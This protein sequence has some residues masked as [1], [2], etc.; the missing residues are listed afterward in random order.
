MSEVRLNV[1]DAQAV[2]NGRIHGSVADAVIASLSAEPETIAELEAALSRFSK[3]NQSPFAS[4]RSGEDARPWDAGIVI[5][6]MAGR[7]IAAESTYS[8]PTAVGEIRYHNGKKGTDVWLPYRIPDDWLIVDSVLEYESRRD[9]RRDERLARPRIDIREVLYG[10]PLIDFIVNE[11]VEEEEKLGY[12]PKPDGQERTESEGDE[13]LIQEIH[14][15][16]L[17]TTLPDLEDRS[18]RDVILEKLNFIDFDLQSRELQWSTFDEGP[19]P[20]PRDSC[21]YLG[22]GFGRHEYL[23]YYDFVRHLLRRCFSRVS[24]HR[25]R[26]V[27]DENPEQ[28]TKVDGSS[29]EGTN[30]SADPSLGDNRVDTV[31]EW[32]EEIGKAWLNSPCKELNGRIPLDVIESERRRI[33]LL[34]SAKDVL[35]DDCPYCQVLAEDAGEQ[36]GKGFW[37]FDGSHIDS[38]F[39]FSTYQTREEWEA[40]ERKWQ[41]Y[42]EEFE[43]R[44]ARDHPTTDADRGKPGEDDIPY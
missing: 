20:L 28:T 7:I 26:I 13:T 9:S 1:M 43:R 30:L 14:C 37:H 8:D 44:W 15:R 38:L 36:L 32:L 25:S 34:I 42:T 27:E 10:M 2:I 33:P 17:M 24:G 31:V 41:E 35:F 4:F 29:Q 5:V 39:E 16:W 11:C 21:A 12:R 19:P 22:G 3:F 6:D 18:P 40:E 23:I